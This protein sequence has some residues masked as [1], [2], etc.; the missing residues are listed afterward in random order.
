MFDNGFGP[1]RSMPICLLMLPY[2]LIK[3]T[4][5]PFP[6]SKAQLKVDRPLGWGQWGG[7]WE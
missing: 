7:G 6:F 2:S 4:V 5:F 1:W 3:R